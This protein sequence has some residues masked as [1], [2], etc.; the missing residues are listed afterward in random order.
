MN[1]ALLMTLHQTVSHQGVRE[2]A[3]ALLVDEVQH[4]KFGWAY[5]AYVQ[6]RREDVGFLAPYV[7]DM[8]RA[9]ASENL[10]DLSRLCQS[11]SDPDRGYLSAQTRIEIF[12]H[13][14]EDVI[15]PGL[16]MH[17]VETTSAR[18]WLDTQTWYDE[19]AGD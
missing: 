16:E 3:H 7:G 2:T 14:L 17:G 6:N 11:W 8:I 19:R 4:A 18:H 15:F 1:A 5:L 13:C 9:S 10:T 12:S